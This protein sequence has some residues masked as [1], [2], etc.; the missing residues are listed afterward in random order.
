[1]RREAYLDFHV[2][3]VPNVPENIGHLHLAM[4]IFTSS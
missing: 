1:M 4:F 3:E 2:E